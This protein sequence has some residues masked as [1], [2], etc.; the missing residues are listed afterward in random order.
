MEVND[1]MIFSWFKKEVNYFIGK[2]REI[3]NPF[4][5]PVILALTSKGQELI[6][7]VDGR[8][9]DFAGQIM[10]KLSN[11]LKDINDDLA[12]VIY[13]FHCI[14]NGSQEAVEK[15]GQVITEIHFN[16]FIRGKEEISD[17]DIYEVVYIPGEKN[18]GMVEISPLYESMSMPL[19]E[20]LE[21][22]W[23]NP[24]K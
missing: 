1:E 20:S 10:E 6:F 2:I 4:Y 5:I 24:I 9:G 19:H 14:P 15:K 8:L 13:Y 7:M 17:S 21:T 22:L 16:L 18:N 23:K 3:R 11:E 12:A